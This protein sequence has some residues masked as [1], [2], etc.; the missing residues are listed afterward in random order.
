MVQAFCL[1]N[2]VDKLDLKLFLVVRDKDR[3]L[4]LFGE[5]DYISYI[6]SNIENLE[7]SKQL[8]QV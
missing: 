4:Q 5:K 6:E 1:K 7:A 3:A 2:E 8:I